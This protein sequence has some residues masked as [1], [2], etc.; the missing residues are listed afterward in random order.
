[1]KVKTLLEQST[2]DERESIEEILEFAVSESIDDYE[3]LLEWD[4]DELDEYISRA[5]PVEY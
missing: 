4:V 3:S 2:L 5:F 1:M